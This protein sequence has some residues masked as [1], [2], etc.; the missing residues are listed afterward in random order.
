M[1][2]SVLKRDARLCERFGDADRIEPLIE[3]RL[4]ELEIAR[5]GQIPRRIGT[6]RLVGHPFE[7]RQPAL[8]PGELPRQPSVLR[9]KLVGGC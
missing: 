4:L 9:Q 2:S 3:K 7:Q 5:R 8:D 6:A 1:P